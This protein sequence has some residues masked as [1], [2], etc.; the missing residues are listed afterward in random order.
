MAKI[1]NLENYP[2]VSSFTGSE[3]LLGSLESGTGKTANFPISILTDYISTINGDFN[4]V[5]GVTDSPEGK[6][7][8]YW[9]ANEMGIYPNF[10]EVE[11]VWIT[12]IITIKDGVFTISEFVDVNTTLIYDDFNI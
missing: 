7:T 8:G 12:G 1:N 2:N 11:N 5:V 4:G 3:I 9:I 10:Q 6:T